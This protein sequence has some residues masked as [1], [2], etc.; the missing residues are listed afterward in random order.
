MWLWFL[1]LRLFVILIGIFVFMIMIFPL[2]LCQMWLFVFVIVIEIV[3]LWFCVIVIVILQF[4][5]GCAKCDCLLPPNSSLAHH[6]LTRFCCCNVTPTDKAKDCTEE[7]LKIMDPG[8]TSDIWHGQWT[9]DRAHQCRWS[10]HWLIIPAWHVCQHILLLNTLFQTFQATFTLLVI[11]ERQSKYQFFNNSHWNGNTRCL[12]VNFH[13]FVL[14]TF[15]QIIFS[16]LLTL[17]SIGSM[18]WWVVAQVGYIHFQLCLARAHILSVEVTIKAH[19]PAAE[20]CRNIMQHK[21]QSNA[22]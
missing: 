6:H 5:C 17:L 2:R 10:L 3:W 20:K 7:Q 22:M 11:S 4:G 19:I 21:V 12:N 15:W 9:L 18:H 14:L 8:W 16:M 1:C 13:W